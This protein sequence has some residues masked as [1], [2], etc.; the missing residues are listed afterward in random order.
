MIKHPKIWILKNL[1]C[2]LKFLG[3]AWHFTDLD[4]LQI[5]C[6]LL[7]AVGPQGPGQLAKWHMSIEL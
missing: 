6:G 1:K 4:P 5:Q 2:R 3:M 7:L